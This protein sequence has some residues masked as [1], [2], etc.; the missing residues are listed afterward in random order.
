MNSPPS[1]LPAAG[2]RLRQAIAE[3]RPLQVVG[4]P[5]AYC[6][7]LAQQAGFRAIYL[8]GAGV[9]N[10]AYGRPDL[11]L[12][13]CAEV[14]EEARRI[15][16]ATPLPLLVDVDTGWGDEVTD[17][18]RDLEQAGAAG[19]QLE[20]QVEEKRCGHR[21]GKMLVSTVEMQARLSAALAARR[22]NSFV[23]MARTDAGSVEGLSAAIDRGLAYIET[24]ADMI[25]VEALT[26]LD[27]YRQFTAAV[28]VP[29]L[30]NLTEFG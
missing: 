4:V 2:Q 19:L 7:L 14:V 3:E 10:M 22:D 28:R 29:V 12:T 20:D 23:I 16:A 27:A 25:F 9:A 26:S 30:A 24:G 1:S 15:T 17:C 8:S 6:A 21:P 5:N 18:V 11:G 13:S